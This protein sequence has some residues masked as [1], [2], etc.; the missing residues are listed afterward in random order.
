MILFRFRR[1][2]ECPDQNNDAGRRYG[3]DEKSIWCG[4]RGLF[5]FP[6]VGVAMSFLGDLPLVLPF[7]SALKARFLNQFHKP[8]TPCACSL[9]ER[10]T[11]FCD[12]VHAFRNIRFVHQ[13][14][15]WVAIPAG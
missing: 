15:R 8:G 11:A 13:Y 7:R 12:Q 2:R 6:A 4:Q 1:S 14:M 3:K 5:V 10:Q 9:S